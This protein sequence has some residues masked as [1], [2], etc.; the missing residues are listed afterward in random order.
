MKQKQ[1]DY[2]AGLLGQARWQRQG[3]GGTRGKRKE[4]GEGKRDGELRLV[5]EKG[6]GRGGGEGERRE[7]GKRAEGQPSEREYGGVGNFKLAQTAASPN[8]K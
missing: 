2:S 3:G 5:G 8:K 7:R 1:N 4:G 6:W